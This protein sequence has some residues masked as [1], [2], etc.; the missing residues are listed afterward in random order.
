M[1]GVDIC[2]ADLSDLT[3]LASLTGLKELYLVSNGISDIS[4]LAGLTGLTRLSLADNNISDTSP[5]ASLTNL[6]WLDLSHNEISNFSPLDG[7]R[8]N[9]KLIWYD[10]PAFPKGGPKIEGPWLWVVLPDAELDS[11]TDLLSEASRGT[12]TEVEIATHGATVGHSVGADVWTSHKL[13]PT[14]W[15]NIEDMLKRSIDGG[16]IYGT[17]SLYSPQEQTTRMYVGSEDEVKV[18][19]NGTLIYERL[20]HWWGNDYQ[21]FFPVT[22]K[23]GRNIL[24]VAVATHSNGFFGFE[25]G[26][27]YTAANSGVGYTFSKTPIHTWRHRLPSTSVRK[28]SSTWQAGNLILPSIPLSWK[29]LT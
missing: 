1:E 2:G 26:T 10:N 9:I 29:L 25:P 17:V 27:E 20:S 18:W 16:V 23:Q 7:L 5:L 19:L 14:G 15:N 11:G 28:M 24:L 13:P 4:S 12:V 21:D 6:T 3:P 8:E 22:L